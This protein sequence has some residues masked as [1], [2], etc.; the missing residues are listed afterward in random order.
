MTVSLPPTDHMILLV[1]SYTHSLPHV[2]ARGR[3]VSI[4][5][6]NPANAGI[7][8]VASHEGVKNPTYL[9]LSRDRR[10]IYGVEEMAEAENSG[11]FVL[12]IGNG[13]NRPVLSG[14][15]PAHG[16]APCHIALDE[17]NSLLMVSN[18]VGGNLVSYVLD[19]QGLPQNEPVLI[20]RR[21]A[22]VPPSGREV[23]S[24]VHQAVFSPSGRHV[25]V[26][27]LGANEIARYPIREGQVSPDADAVLSCGDGTQPRHLVFS[28]DGRHAYIVNEL[29]NSVSVC[30][31]D[32]ETGLSPLQET[33][34]LPGDFAGT[35]HAAAIRLHPNGRFVYVSNRG[36]DSIAAFAIAASGDRL[37][38]VGIYPSGG[39]IPRDFVIDPSGRFLICANQD[40]HSLATF[41]LDPCTGELVDLVTRFEIGSPVNLVFA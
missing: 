8:L 28:A 6:F 11:V 41:S 16:G 13:R 39:R 17:E 27:D 35:S 9:T 10:R 2:V 1:G 29:A 31:Y 37:E 30:R 18:Y 20:N 12:D 24:H 21:P 23:V 32:E 40:S 25:L 36:H 22:S 34:T 33:P 19:A 4:L 7:A 14:H 15:V 3:G 38:L 5:S 26:C